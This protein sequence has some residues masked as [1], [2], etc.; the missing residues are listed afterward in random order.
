M[1][2]KFFTL[3]ISVIILSTEYKAADTPVDVEESSSSQRFYGLIR[4]SDTHHTSRDILL[5]QQADSLS[6]NHTM[7]K[8]LLASPLPTSADLRSM[9]PDPFDQG[10]LGSC[11]ANALVGVVLFELMQ[12]KVT[13]PDMRSRLYLY[14]QA[15][16]LE[17]TVDQD[18]GASISDGIRVLNSKGVCNESLWPY[19]INTF[20]NPPTA[21]MDSD[22][23]TCKATNFSSVDRDL[24]VFKALLSQNCPIVGGISVYELLES[25]AVKKSGVANIPGPNEKFLGGHGVVFVGY[26]D[27]RQAFLVRNSWGPNWGI[28]GCFWL[29]YEYILRE[30]LSFDFWKITQMTIPANLTPSTNPNDKKCCIIL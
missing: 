6:T 4:D 27:S 24:N 7:V 11:L 5:A 17:G 2:K 12:E 25:A 23:A 20:K 16:N 15:R 30:D 29:P 1:Y 14:W 13:N 10:K 18:A 21:A 22:A 19:D 9:F 28:K 3:F 8:A 26:D